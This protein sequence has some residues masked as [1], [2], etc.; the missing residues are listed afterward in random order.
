MTRITA[1][2]DGRQVSREEVISWERRRAEKVLAK[3]QARVRPTDIGELRRAH[4]ERKL[5]LGHEE[6]E[7]RLAC[8][9]RAAEYVG[10]VGVGASRSRRRTCSIELTGEGASVEAI[11]HWYSEAITRNNEVPLIEACPDHYISRAHADG[12]QEVIETTGG[13]PTPVRMF[14]RDD[15]TSTLRSKPDPTFPVEWASVALSNNGVPIG[16]VRHLFRDEPSGFRIRLTVEFPL[17]TPTHMIRQHRWHLACEFSNWIE[18]AAA[19]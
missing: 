8:A 3:L 6:I 18:A 4:V 13:S 9:L 12:R 10:R 17:T 15:D 1:L 16:G 2:L 11:P 19:S 14:F 5:E 7:Q